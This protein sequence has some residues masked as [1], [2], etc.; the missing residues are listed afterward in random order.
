MI[1]YLLSFGDR[2]WIFALFVYTA[3]C[4]RYLVI[5]GVPYA[6][7]WRIFEKKMSHRRIQATSKAKPLRIGFEILWSCSSFLV[8]A[9][10]A[11]IV[12]ALYIHG[13]TRLVTSWSDLPVWLH[14]AEFVLLFVIHDAYFYWM[15]RL[16][17]HRTLFR[18]VHY[19]HH[20]SVNPTP[21]AAFA[22]HPVEAF[23]ETAFL[24]PILLWCPL[25]I[26]TLIG[27]LFLSHLFNVIGHLGYELFPQSSRKSPFFS[28]ITTSTHHNLHHQ[29]V[30]SNYGLYWK[31]WDQWGGTM[32]PKT[33]VEFMKVTGPALK[34]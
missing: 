19:V 5:S 6:L 22:F 4:A 32:N 8:F 12:Y 7:A 10:E 18:H 27:F 14:V 9:I 2:A 34:D 24:I 23:L 33:E 30:L 13:H 1:E 16:L 11:G 29:H 26:G 3:L 21:F 20:Q 31:I 25:Y 15:H 28:W 17:H